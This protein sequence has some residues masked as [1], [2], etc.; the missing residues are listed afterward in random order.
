MESGTLE[1]GH[2]TPIAHGTAQE[3]VERAAAFFEDR[4]WSSEPGV[5]TR[6]RLARAGVEAA[7]IRDF[8]VGYA[9]GDVRALL[10]HFADL[11]Y[12][13]EELVTAGVATQSGREHLHVIFHARVIFPIRD[14]DGTALG[15]AGLATH[16]GPSWPLWVTS[17]PGDLFRAGAAIFGIERAL[18]PISEARRAL[19]KRDC[20]EVM[21]LHQDGRTEAVGVIQSPITGDHLA[22]L[23]RPL[24]VSHRDLS[25]VRNSG[26]DAVLVQPPGGEV[27]PE[28]FGPRERPYGPAP[29]AATIRAD[30]NGKVESS[31]VV[32][33]ENEPQ[34]ARG[35]V[36][37]G[38]ILIGAAIPLGT[39]VLGPDTG[40][41]GGATPALNVVIA[42]VAVSYLVL[43]VV[44]SHISARRRAQSTTRRMRLPWVRGSGEVQPVGWTYHRLEEI[45]IGAALVSAVVCIVLWMTVGGF[46]G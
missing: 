27:M 6:S 37:V 9:P 38:G 19:I 24:G 2:V 5:R 32:V 42:A 7:T 28:D 22:Q 17:P 10:R 14:S 13:E 3:I 44:V 18:A 29:I 33:Y 43:A 45:L 20:V 35:I 46:L 41:P 12:A 15:F 34:R 23:A 16:L 31:E 36:Y 25:V 11:G 40:G 4:L 39:L 8:G 26:L 21:R 30:W 1:D